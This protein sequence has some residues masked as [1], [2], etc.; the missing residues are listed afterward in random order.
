[1]DKKPSKQHKT[2]YTAEYSRM[3]FEKVHL[4]A[5]Q[6]ACQLTYFYRKTN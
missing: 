5:V 3:V 1:M 4:N 2:T 6:L